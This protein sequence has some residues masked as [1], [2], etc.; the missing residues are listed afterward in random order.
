MVFVG[1]SGEQRTRSLHQGLPV[2]HVTSHRS[3]LAHQHSENSRCWA[4]HYSEQGASGGVLQ[5]EVEDV[6]LP[7]HENGPLV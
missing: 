5:E 3:Q 1:F 2:A 7:L 6:R 4:G